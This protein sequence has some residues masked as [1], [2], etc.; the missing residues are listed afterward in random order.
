MC[1][2]P[3]CKKQ[4]VYGMP[5]E[6]PS[7]CPT[8]RSPSMISM[9]R[10]KT[11][12]HTGCPTHASFGTVGGRALY[13]SSH[14]LEGMIC[15]SG[16][17]CS[18]GV[19]TASASYGIVG[20]KASRC[21]K[22]RLENMTNLTG[23]RCE[24]V[25]CLSRPCYGII[26]EKATRCAKHK[27]ENMSNVRTKMCVGPM[28][29]V[30]PSYGV[31]F[32]RPLY[33][34]AHKSQDSFYV[35]KLRCQTDGC[36][37]GSGY[38][39]PGE[40]PSRCS[41]HR[42]ENMVNLVDKFCAHDGCKVIPVYGI[43]GG[44]ASHCLAHRLSNMRDVKNSTCK[45]EWCST[46][47]RKTNE[48]YCLHCYVNLFPDKPTSRNYKTKERAVAEF[49]MGA[50]PDMDWKT[51]RIVADGCSRRRPDM[52]LDL[53]YQVIIVETDENSHVAYD[54]SCDN[55]RTMELSRDVGHRPLVM[56]RFN[57]DSYKTPAGNI[58]S[59]WGQ[60]GRGFCV[61]KKT[62]KA[63]WSQRLKALA[64]QIT[65]WAHPTNKTEKTVE[66]IQLFYDCD[67]PAQLEEKEPE[68]PP[69]QQLEPATHL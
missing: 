3:G 5:G 65:Y 32:G 45:S 58:T 29:R 60:D 26:G 66:V 37:V 52:I 47:V 68:D 61:V 63:E 49:V 14:Q 1:K 8:H 34:N 12:E 18:F 42:L 33:C 25:G 41:K 48:G 6:R 36:K 43:P 50:F 35:R 9:K 51:D 28:C 59:C 7:H 20:G 64:D 22:H 62:K 38:G 31:V 10:R 67:V 16:T 55:K 17:K 4:S 69:A 19:C 15:L 54:C 39:I 44:K 46:A 53:G 2:H 56:L 13:C 24:H 40:R 30:T 27:L 11:C 23:K 21:A 57:P